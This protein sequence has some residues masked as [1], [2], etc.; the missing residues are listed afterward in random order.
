MKINIYFI[1]FLLL[2]SC[3]KNDDKTIII[4]DLTNLPDGVLYLYEDVYNNRIDSVITKKGKFFMKHTWFD[5]LDEPVYLG[6]DHIS[7][8]GV[9]RAFSFPT[10]SKFKDDGYN[11]TY[12]FSDSIVTIKGKITEFEPVS[13]KLSEKVKLVVGPKIFAGYQTNALYNLDGDLF[14]NINKTSYNI[15]LSKII[16]FPNSYHL[17]FQ[18]NNNRNSFTP[19]QVKKLLSVFKGEIIK[20]ETFNTLS[21]YNAK[22]LENNKIAIPLLLDNSGK[23]VAILNPE[24]KKHLVVFWASWCG[25]CR[26]EIPALKEIYK[27]HNKDIEFVSI[28]TDTNNSSWQKAVVKENMPWKQLIVNENSKEYE[29]IEI[30]FQ[31]SNSIPY[32]ALIDNNMKVLKSTVGS[33]T[34]KELEDFLKD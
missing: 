32:V 17:L 16:E 22:R 25:P 11:S 23:K 8:T 19:L 9:L 26:Q 7:K 34:E 3:N 20:S 14:E 33:M 24:Y 10:N 12:F 18:I 30:C 2:L 13:V 29:P 31:V 1:F 28:S 21:D 15:V 4:G 6:L 5:G 27:K